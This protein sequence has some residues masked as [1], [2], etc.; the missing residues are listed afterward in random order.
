MCMCDFFCNFQF[1]TVHLWV[2]SGT[3]VQVTFLHRGSLFCFLEATKAISLNKFSGWGFEDKWETWVRFLGWEDLL[4]KGMATHSSILAWRI[5]WTGEPGRLE[6]MGSQRVQHNWETFT[7]DYEFSVESTF[8]LHSF[9]RL[10]PIINLSI[11][12]LR[13]GDF[14]F[15][16]FV[17]CCVCLFAVHQYNVS[18]AFS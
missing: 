11:I 9:L 13:K 7:C 16:S 2:F 12:F 5:S 1:Q 4:E 8:S 14:L 3:C 17:L 15:V 10:Q 6:S 18:G